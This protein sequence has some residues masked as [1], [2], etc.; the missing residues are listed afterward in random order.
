[1]ENAALFFHLLGAFLFVSGTVLAGVA[2]EAARRRQTPAEVALLLGL[3]RVAVAF[4]GVGGALVGVFGLWLVSLG[5]FG[6]RSGWVSAAIALFIVVLALG[7]Y[8][9]QTPAK[10]RRLATALAEQNGSMTEELRGLLDDVPSRAANYGALM[11]VVVIVV[12]MV[13]K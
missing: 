9:G 5:H 7:A 12:L 4:V 3:A 2:F 10:A 13:F 1:M 8:G 11:L 6:Y